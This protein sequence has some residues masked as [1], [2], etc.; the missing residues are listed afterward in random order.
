M[1]DLLCYPFGNIKLKQKCNK[2]KNLM[3]RIS[4]F[5]LILICLFSNQLLANTANNL[6]V[7]IY[8]RNIAL[9]RKVRNL[10]LEKG[11]QDFS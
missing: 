8:N 7:T 10:P 4:F 9:V 1:N 11:F 3:K 6:A 5:L 2:M